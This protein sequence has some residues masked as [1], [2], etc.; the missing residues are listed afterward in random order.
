MALSHPL[1]QA[2]VRSPGSPIGPVTTPPSSYGNDLVARP[3]P[4]DSSSGLVM[5]GNVGGGMHF[6]GLV[7]YG[8]QT[9]LRA[10]LGSTYLDSFL[11][12]S[13]GGVDQRPDLGGLVPFYSPTASVT[14]MAPGS[15]DPVVPLAGWTGLIPSGGT[16]PNVPEGPV[17]EA[18]QQDSPTEAWADAQKAVRTE[19]RTVEW[20]WLSGRL[21]R[22]GDA[23]QPAMGLDGSGV[24]D[25]TGL[26]G[27][28]QDVTPADPCGPGAPEAPAGLGSQ[29][30]SGISQRTWT[31]PV[32]AFTQ[33]R[34]EQCMVNAGACLKEGKVREASD[35]Y[36][37]ALIYRPTDTAAL[38]GRS[39]A[40]FM[41]GEY[42]SSALFLA[43]ALEICPDY[44]KLP[45]DLAALVGGQSVLRSRI[46][47]AAMYLRQDGSPELHL[48]LA[49]ACYRSGDM[50][51]AKRTL[52]AVPAADRLG[53]ALRVLGRA[54]DE[55]ATPT[56]P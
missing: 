9:D 49:Y 52:A 3:D 21:G 30:G 29:Q 20:P 31:G 12:S 15:A 47:E 11:R 4:M 39:H 43:R 36:A 45:V 51:S 46:E 27:Q 24:R 13:Q 35:A 18:M 41:C 23:N 7:P 34:Y 54:V 55:A 33:G 42:T 53:G 50:A 37:L 17:I 44:V 2:V 10:T 6:R 14:R 38:A 28:V 19:G 48:I 25:V 26:G 40:L 56:G 22:F 16:Q 1:C 32:E 5:T 8:S